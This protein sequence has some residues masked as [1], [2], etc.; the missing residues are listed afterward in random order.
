MSTPSGEVQQPGRESNGL[1]AAM[2]VPL[3]DV[4]GEVGRLLLG[5]LARAR[6]AAYLT[7]VPG[8]NPA[9]GTESGSTGG[10]AA[11]AAQARRRLFVAADERAD[12]RTIVASV[13]KSTDTAPPTFR[14]DP[15]RDPLAGVDTETAFAELVAD[16]HVD[17]V[18]AVREAERRLR[19]EDA[20]WRARLVRQ[21]QPPSD[22]LVWLD[23]D[24]Y[25]P[26]PPPPL[27]RLSGPTVGAIALVA[28]AIV[29]L[30]F[31]SRIAMGTDVR[32]LLGIGSIL[33]AGY[34][35]LTRLRPRT[36]EDEDD[37]GA[38]I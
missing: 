1:L 13:L 17:T 9:G 18:Q 14:E 2:Y 19:E 11:S 37:D 28:F 15:P 20:D 36:D 23:D 29:V 38:V 3:T 35:L 22:D 6:I 31:G 33:A 8:G 21:A 10:D 4:E 24:H 27:P 32:F 12:A 25:V 5:T 16:W 7:A 26:P 34:L 30:A